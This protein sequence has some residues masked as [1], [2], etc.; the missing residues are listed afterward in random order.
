VL[1]DELWPIVDN[2][3]DF[4]AHAKVGIARKMLVNRFLPTNRWGRR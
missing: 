1:G 2:A 4:V 3:A